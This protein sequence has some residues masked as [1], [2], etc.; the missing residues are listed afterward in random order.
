M[1]VKYGCSERGQQ[2]IQPLV[3]GATRGLGQTEQSYREKYETL[4][5]EFLNQVLQIL[6]MAVGLGIREMWQSDNH[7]VH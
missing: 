5:R 1:S 6:V 7:V 2:C 4:N 3:P